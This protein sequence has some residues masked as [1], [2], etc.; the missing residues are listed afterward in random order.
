MPPASSVSSCLDPVVIEISSLRRWCISVAVVKPMGT[1]LDA[2][3]SS[4]EAFCS[5]IPLICS[6]ARRGLQ[7]VSCGVTHLAHFDS[8]VS[9]GFDSVEATFNNEFNVARGQAVYTLRKVLASTRVVRRTSLPQAQR[10]VWERRAL[11]FGCHPRI[12]APQY[13]C[14][15]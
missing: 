11:P 2:S 12:V 9:N 7:L 10:Q 3:A 1:S 15:L 5:E 8:R 6:S 4:F 14:C 13:S